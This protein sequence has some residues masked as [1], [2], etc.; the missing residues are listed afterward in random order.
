MDNE[1]ANL[2]SDD[3]YDAYEVLSPS[4]AKSLSQSKPFL[5][6]KIP[7]NVQSASRN[8]NLKQSNSDK[9]RKKI[10][11]GTT[12]RSNKKNLD[13]FPDKD[14]DADEMDQNYSNYYSIT[15]RKQADLTEPSPTRSYLED[16]ITSGV[17]KSITHKLKQ[18]KNSRRMT[19]SL[20]K[21][22]PSS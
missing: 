11:N 6:A 18:N 19:S 1:A 13:A 7:T 17:E 22:D 15:A 14:G 16:S 3:Q 20:S 21:K 2:S 12:N 9:K 5:Q 10:K 4:A 8:S